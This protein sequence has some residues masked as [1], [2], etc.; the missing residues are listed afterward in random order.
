MGYGDGCPAAGGGGL[1]LLLD[2]LGDYI[3]IRLGEFFGGDG[4]ALAVGEKA[5]DGPPVIEEVTAEV[6]MLG[7]EADEGCTGLEEVAGGVDELGFDGVEECGEVSNCGASLLSG[8]GGDG[9]IAVAVHQGAVVLG[10][11]D[12]PVHRGGE[13]LR[14]D[15]IEEYYA[16]VVLVL[17]DGCGDAVFKKASLDNVAESFEGDAGVGDSVE[18]G[19]VPFVVVAV[20]IAFGSVSDGFKHLGGAAHRAGDALEEVVDGFL[21]GVGVLGAVEV[22]GDVAK[23]EEDAIDVAANLEW[24]GAAAVD[25]FVDLFGEGFPV[26]PFSGL[27]RVVVDDVADGV[28]LENDGVVKGGVAVGDRHTAQQGEGILPRER[29]YEGVHVHFGPRNL[30]DF[31]ST[32]RLGFSKVSGIFET[33]K[34]GNGEVINNCFPSSNQGR[35]ERGSEGENKI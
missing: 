9:G 24:V 7:A 35:W 29:L 12:G 34:R 23:R 28:L 5:V 26:G 21:V 15:F 16:A 27:G 31:W 13:L 19:L 18:A 8:N 22:R 25:G 1:R 6:V 32:L 17:K 2:G 4:T 20:Q 3:L 11:V 14:D 10:E 30:L 33:G